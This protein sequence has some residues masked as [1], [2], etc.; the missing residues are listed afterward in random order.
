MMKKLMTGAAFV[1]IPI[2]MYQ[3][4]AVALLW[5]CN[6]VFTAAQNQVL[7]SAGVRRVLGL[8]IKGVVEKPKTAAEGGSWFEQQWQQRRGSIPTWLGGSKVSR[9]K[10]RAAATSAAAAGAPALGTRVA[11]NYVSRKPSKKAKAS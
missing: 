9:S 11:V 1:M 2:G 3:S 10:A 5:A 6:A 4:S 8:P 7:G